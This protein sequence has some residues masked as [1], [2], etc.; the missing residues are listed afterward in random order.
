MVFADERSP[1]KFFGAQ[2]IHSI[3]LST[4]L[5]AQRTIDSDSFEFFR[6]LNIE[7]EVECE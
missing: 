4:H 3:D 5:E 6:V 2:W 1:F 7:N